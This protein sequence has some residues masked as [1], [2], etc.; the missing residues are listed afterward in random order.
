MRFRTEITAERLRELLDYDPET[1]LFTWRVTVNNRAW[2]G[3][4][5]D[6]INHAGYNYIGIEGQRYLAHRLAWLY[7]HGN[8]P[9]KEIDHIN[10]VRSDNRFCNLREATR[11]LNARNKAGLGYRR[12]GNRF[13]A[14]IRVNRKYLYLGTF[15]TEG[16]ARS[17]YLA[18]RSASIAE[19]DSVAWRRK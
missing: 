4:V 9:S 11:A 13:A 1:G 5:A 10:R 15:D 17:A 7:V 18:A 19:A 14:A 6:A 3:T 2:A 16:Q 8:W 12:K